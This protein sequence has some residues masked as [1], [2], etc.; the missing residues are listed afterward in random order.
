MAVLL[1]VLKY[2]TYNLAPETGA[3]I[4]G[5]SESAPFRKFPLRAPGLKHTPQ[6]SEGGICAIARRRQRRFDSTPDCNNCGRMPE[7]WI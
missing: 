5:D 3:W 7:A 4:I 2:P 1:V 6:Q